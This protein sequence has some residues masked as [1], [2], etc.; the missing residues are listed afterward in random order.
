MPLQ[1]LSTVDLALLARR[2]TEIRGTEV[3]T[4]KR[5]SDLIYEWEPRVMPEPEDK[6]ET[7]TLVHATGKTAGVASPRWL[8]H[9]LGLRHR[10][11]HIAF[12]T[13][14]GLLALQRRSHSKADWPDALDMSVA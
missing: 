5:I 7:F 4:S 2:F 8:V 6:L 10:A 12:R 1:P 13:E 11:V 9:L 3:I 14:T